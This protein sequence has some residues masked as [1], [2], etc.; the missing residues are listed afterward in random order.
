MCRAQEVV[1]PALLLVL[2][3]PLVF[4]LLLPSFELLVL[5]YNFNQPMFSKSWGFGVLGFWGFGFRV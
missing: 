1:F 4:T 5:N 3:N 2:V